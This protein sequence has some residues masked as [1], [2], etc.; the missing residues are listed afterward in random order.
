[1]THHPFSPSRLEQIRLCPGSWQMQ[2]GLP[3]QESEYAKEGQLLHDA[4]A[5]GNFE[6][7]TGDQKSLCEECQNVVRALVAVHGKREINY[8]EYVQIKDYITGEPL[9][10][11]TADVIIEHPDDTISVIDWKFGWNP[12]NDVANNIQLA[13]YA[14]GAMQK[15]NKTSCRCYVFQ[16]RIKNKSSHTFTGSG[17]IVANIELLIKRASDES[18]MRLNP[19]ESACRYCLARLNCPA[20]RVKFQKL[21][22]ARNDYDLT[23]PNILSNLYEA[24]KGLKTF[25]SDIEGRVKKYIAENGKCGKWVIE[26]SEGSR[27][28]DNLNA[29]Y[30]LIKDFVTP[31]EFNEICSVSVPQ[32]ENLV[33]EKL[34]AEAKARGE[35]LTKDAA[36]KQVFAMVNPL[37]YRASPSQK[38]VEAA[39]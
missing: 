14:V 34:I 28:I 31:R 5:S 24:S 17:A 4:V 9:T 25:I 1:M 38:I 27:K 35:K 37:I 22:A 33:A 18:N 30:D 6:N 21:A 23:N 3:E 15:F 13:A 8:E 2:Q 29:L 16:P 36:K 11:G 39:Q 20:F 32:M 19:S 7:L 10:E 26:T 12:V